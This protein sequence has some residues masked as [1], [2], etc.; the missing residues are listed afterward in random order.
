MKTIWFKNKRY[1]WGWY[2]AT[3]Q[4]W[5]VLLLYMALIV[6]SFRSSD[7][8]SHSGSDTLINL[9]PRLVLGTIILLVICYV[10]GEKPRW[11]CGEKKDK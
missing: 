4:G 1:G 3:W 11:Q 10:K 7:I 9:F 8:R 2:P 5:F 6:Y